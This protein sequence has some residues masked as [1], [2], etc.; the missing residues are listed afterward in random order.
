MTTRLLAFT[1]LTLFL[2]TSCSKDYM[3]SRREDKLIGY[4]EIE[5]VTY[6]E[7]GDIFRDNV[8]HFFDGDYIEF[9]P[10][11]YAFYDDRSIDVSF[12]GE[13]IIHTADPG[14]DD[15]DCDFF[16]D[17]TFYD[18]IRDEGFGYFSSINL[19]T[20]RKLNLTAHDRNGVYTF[21]LRK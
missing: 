12:D 8:S 13:W 18:H 3:I 6:R 2:C 1:T 15:E 16:L 7:D 10:D 11:Y 5:K 14:F 21:K 9:T 20:Q 4:W 17:M 19:L